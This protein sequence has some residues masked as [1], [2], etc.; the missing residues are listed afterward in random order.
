MAKRISDRQRL[1]N[2][3]FQASKREEI[4]AMIESLVSIRDNLFPPMKVSKRPPRKKV[5]AT[6]ASE[7]PS[8]AA[9]QAAAGTYFQDQS[10]STE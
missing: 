6:K 9:A 4:D 5:E 3:A 10:Q 7:K 8:K 1:I 2:A